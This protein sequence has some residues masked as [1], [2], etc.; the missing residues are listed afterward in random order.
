MHANTCSDASNDDC[1][2]PSSYVPFLFLFE[3]ESSVLAG[4]ENSPPARIPESHG[5]NSEILDPTRA[6]GAGTRNMV[7]RGRLTRA[8]LAAGGA[9]NFKKIFMTSSLGSAARRSQSWLAVSCAG[10]GVIEPA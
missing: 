2:S 5:K 3:E 1:S 4:P 8:D 6:P 9:F 7:S 10:C